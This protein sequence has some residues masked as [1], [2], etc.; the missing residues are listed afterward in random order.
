MKDTVKQLNELKDEFF[1][2]EDF[3]TAL[4]IS[5]IVCTLINERGLI[6]AESHEKQLEIIN[7]LSKK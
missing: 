4:R 7:R 3:L 1:K 2:K 6:Y 5:K